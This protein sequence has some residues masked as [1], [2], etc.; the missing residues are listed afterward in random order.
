MVKQLVTME[1]T[2]GLETIWTGGTGTVS[3]M[4]FVAGTET[5]AWTL[6]S[7]TPQ[8]RGVALPLSLVW[9]CVSSEAS[10]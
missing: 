1:R 6:L 7:T 4:N 10:T 2:Q 5:A 9:T 8:N 3:V